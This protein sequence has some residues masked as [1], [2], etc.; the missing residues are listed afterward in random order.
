MKCSEI[1]SDFYIFNGKGTIQ[2]NSAKDNSTINAVQN[3]FNSKNQKVKE[4]DESDKIDKKIEMF[5]SYCWKDDTV[6]DQIE[7]CLSC[8]RNIRLHRDKLDIGPWK[9]IKEYMQ[10]ISHMDYIVLLISDSYLKSENCMYEVLE[11]MRD[12]AYKDKIFPAVINTEIYDPVIQARYVKYWQRK[13][14][15]LKDELDG[16]DYQN[17][18]KLGE[19]LKCRQDIASN[20]AEFL[21]CVS[22]MNNP[23]VEDVCEAIEQKLR[24][25]K[26]II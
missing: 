1:I 9:S 20:I 17:V 25:E 5:L 8:N 24:K 26:M 23:C 19:D 12:R 18:G 10:S 21:N 3:N 15:E 14:K 2:V 16:M 13:Y 7:D 22:D 6:A 11:V 4:S